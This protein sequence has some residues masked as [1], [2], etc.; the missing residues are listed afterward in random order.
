MRETLQEA[1]DPPNWVY[2]PTSGVISALTVLERG[3]MIEF[4]TIGREGTIGVPIALAMGL[5]NL[6]LVSQV[7]GW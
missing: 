3:M 6:A 5:S 2:F 4:A 1:G 7:P